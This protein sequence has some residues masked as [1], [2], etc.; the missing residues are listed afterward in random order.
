MD[1]EAFQAAGTQVYES[2]VQAPDGARRHVVFHK[3]TF[4]DPNGGVGGLVGIVT[5]ITGLKQAE[6]ELRESE[7]RFRLMAETIQ[8]VFWIST[9]DIGKTVYVSPAYEHSLGTSLCR[10]L[11][12]SSPSL[13]GGHPSGGPGAG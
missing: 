6:T 10:S 9:S 2:R 8:D 7:Q 11:Y 4:P 5:D 12:R 13:C 3:A 1:L